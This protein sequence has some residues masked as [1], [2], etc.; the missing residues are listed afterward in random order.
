MDKIELIKNA[1]DIELITSKKRFLPLGSANKLLLKKGLISNFEKNE[2]FLKS[3]LEKELIRGVQTQEKPR[4]WRI[5]L[6]HSLDENL[7]PKRGRNS[8]MPGKASRKDK[9][10]INRIG[11]FT[12]IVIIASLFY[13]GQ[14]SYQN[15][16]KQNAPYKLESSD[17]KPA[18]YLPPSLANP[19]SSEIFR[20]KNIQPKEILPL[21]EVKITLEAGNTQKVFTYKSL[22]Y[23]R[24]KNGNIL[25]TNMEVTYHTF[26]FINNTVIQRSRFN[27]EWIELV[28]PFSSFYV[29]KGLLSSTYVL[30]VGTLGVK[31]I[32]WSPEVPNLGYDYDDGTRLSC[33]DLEIVSL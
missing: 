2:G 23:D 13:F 24:E 9:F 30:E 29:E 8:K 11:I 1:L 18:V 19:D 10:S 32:W 31:E 28:Y 6:S 14:R 22:F 20:S 15:I 16:E 3:L 17:R 21:K 12:G 25:N 4:Q 5:Y 27:G 7:N 33:Y 26:N